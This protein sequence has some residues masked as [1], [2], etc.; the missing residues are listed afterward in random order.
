LARCAT[1]G[2]PGAGAAAH[3]GGDEHH[4]APAEVVADEFRVV[5]GRLPSDVRVRPRAEALGQLGPELQ[6]RRRKVGAQRLGVGVGGEKLDTGQSGRDHRVDGVAAPT[7]DSHHLDTGPQA[8]TLANPFD[9][10]PL[11]QRGPAPRVP[12]T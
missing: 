4:V 2:A 12:D 6:L 5:E 10:A 1:T 9:H 11:L 3:A 7:P 8:F